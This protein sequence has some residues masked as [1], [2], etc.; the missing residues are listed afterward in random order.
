VLPV[1]RQPIALIGIIFFVALGVLLARISLQHGIQTVLQSY[2]FVI[3]A[4][5]ICAY[6]ASGSLITSEMGAMGVSIWKFALSIAVEMGIGVAGT[7]LIMNKAQ[8]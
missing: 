4:A 1:N 8:K 2:I 3:V 7:V 6:L 5:I